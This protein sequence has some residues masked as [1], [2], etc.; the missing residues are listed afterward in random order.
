LTYLVYYYKP[1]LIVAPLKSYLSVMAMVFALSGLTASAAGLFAFSNEREGW[2]FYP[3]LR[4]T[5]STLV[6]VGTFRMLDKAAFGLSPQVVLLD[7]DP[8][9]TKFN[10]LL[11]AM[12]KKPRIQFLED[13]LGPRFS[14]E[15][16]A[17]IERGGK[18]ELTILRKYVLPVTRTGIVTEW[19]YD[20]WGSD[21]E[22]STQ[23]T[24]MFFSHL[25]NFLE[26]DLWAMTCLGNP[27]AYRWIRRMAQEGK[28]L[29]AQGSLENPDD[30]EEVGAL[31]RATQNPLVSTLDISNAHNYFHR[32]SVSFQSALRKLSFTAEAQL[33]MTQFV[34]ETSDGWSYL[35]VPI[36]TMLGSHGTEITDGLIARWSVEDL[37]ML[38]PIQDLNE[39]PKGPI[40]AQCRS[41]LVPKINVR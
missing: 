25:L 27:A 9:T 14:P 18:E 22:A 3:S 7:V 39:L 19:A 26:E 40:L 16:K 11:L 31:I 6:G 13:L 33:F 8:D 23:G 12:L 20:L 15:E 24:R 37:Q 2:R 35:S 29:V 34:A 1:G 41:L 28:I 21:Y 4:H 5:G 17:S 32:S 10:R 38:G 36:K 30:M